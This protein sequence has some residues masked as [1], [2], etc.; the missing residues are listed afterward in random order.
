[1]RR[2][3]GSVVF[4]NMAGILIVRPRRQLDQPGVGR[5]EPAAHRSRTAREV[6]LEVDVQPLAARGPS[7]ALGDGDQLA[8]DAQPPADVAVTSVSMMNAWRLAVPRHVHEAHQL[9]VPAGRT[10]SPGCAVRPGRASRRSSARAR[11]PRRAA[12]SPRG[13]GTRRATRTPSPRVDRRGPLTETRIRG[14]RHRARGRRG[15]RRRRRRA[16]RASARGR[17]PRSAGVHGR[18]RHS[19]VAG[20]PRPSGL[21]SAWLL[22]CSC[23]TCSTGTAA[24]RW[25]RTSRS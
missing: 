19:A 7:L 12:R 6:I 15:R 14:R 2:P 9:A 18:L 8:A 5:R 23:P 21:P 10:P 11:T 1:M 4:L 13:F 25:P 20:G 17:P 16:V 22:P 3:L 24:R